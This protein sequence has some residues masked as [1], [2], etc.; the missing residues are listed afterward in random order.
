MKKRRGKRPKVSVQIATTKT[1]KPQENPTKSKKSQLHHQTWLRAIRA[2]PWW[3]A[4]WSL[5]AGLSLI[6]GLLSGLDS[7]L[8]GPIW[9][10]DPDIHPAGSDPGS[11]FSLPFSVTNKSVIF[12]DKASRIT[13]LLVNMETRG[14][15]TF[16]NTEI[17]VGPEK[18]IKPTETVNFSCG[19][20]VPPN[21]V[22]SAQLQIRMK[23]RISIFGISVQQIYT[24][25]LFSWVRTSDGGRWI[26]GLPR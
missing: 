6:V 1:S 20:A 19:I 7:I 14:N 23:Y 24:S 9:P 3:V 12:P 8:G 25:N 2:H 4:A 11:P 18:D 5:V 17:T 16:K 21:Y 15:N 26:V 13:C 22:V 10:T